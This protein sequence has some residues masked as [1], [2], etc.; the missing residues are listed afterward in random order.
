MTNEPR[1]EDQLANLH[2][3]ISFGGTLPIPGGIDPA[4]RFV[5]ATYYLNSLTAPATYLDALAKIFSVA[6][7]VA[8]PL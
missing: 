8:V 7:N 4:S 6:N 5:R 2:N 1:L 3:Y